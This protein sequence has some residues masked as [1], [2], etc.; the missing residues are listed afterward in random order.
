MTCCAGGQGGE[1]PWGRGH[2]P[3]AVHPAPRPAA[4]PAGRGSQRGAGLAAHLPDCVPRLLDQIGD[5]DTWSVGGLQ[6]LLSRR[7]LQEVCAVHEAAHAVVTHRLG[8]VVDR[9]VETHDAVGDPQPDTEMTLSGW[10]NWRPGQMTR[11]QIAAMT[12]AGLVATKRW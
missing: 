4:R 9:V 6:P 12:M 8:G 11:P 3:G 1:R 7:E 5:V 10:V 2:G